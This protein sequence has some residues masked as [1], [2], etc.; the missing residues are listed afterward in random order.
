MADLNIHISF[1]HMDAFLKSLVTKSTCFHKDAKP[2]ITV[3]VPRMH[4]WLDI[5]PAM[6]LCNAAPG[7]ILRF[8][9]TLHGSAP[10]E[11]LTHI[12]KTCRTALPST[13][14]A[15]TPQPIL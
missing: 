10:T 9:S 8:Q 12:F 3:H 13:A 7:L 2:I 6:K 15:A 4:E 14:S 5:T 11:G 1:P